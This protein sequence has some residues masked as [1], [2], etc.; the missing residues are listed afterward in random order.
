MIKRV[1]LIYP[2]ESV[3]SWLSRLYSQ[4]GYLFHKHFAS[5]IFVSK[6]VRV[7]F[8]FINIFNT[9]FRKIVKTTIGFKELLLNHT[10]FKYYGRFINVEERKIVYELGIH[11]RELLSKHLHILS[12]KDNYYLRYCPKCVCEDREKYGECY[13]HIEHQIYDIHIC[14]IH[15]VELVNTSIIND[16]DNDVSFVPL[17][18]LEPKEECEPRSVDINYLVTKYIYDVFSQ[19]ININNKVIISDYLSSLLNRTQCVDVACTK[20]NIIKLT[21][22]IDLFFKEL[23]G[24]TF[25]N[26]K[27]C[28]IYRGFCINPYDVLLI[29]YYHKIEP[30][31]IS[32]LVLPKD[33]IRRPIM[34]R[35][36]DLYNEGHDVRFIA[37]TVG[38]KEKQVIKIINGYKK[39]KKQA[40]N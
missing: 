11:N 8:N 18:Q 19:K 31:I 3:Y 29:C 33:K 36:Y 2:N 15:N 39:I 30:K 38:R 25:T 7:D 37:K 40:L 27:V 20:K 4:S 21:K 16:K 1:P 22:D 14:P 6:G 26:Y 9:S 17:E 23:S 10:L 13:F 28:D 34:R 35:V 5:E 24:K 32:N 12:K